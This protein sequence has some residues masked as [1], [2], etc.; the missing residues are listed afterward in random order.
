MIVSL[1][2]LQEMRV[3]LIDDDADDDDGSHVSITP[4]IVRS[5]PPATLN[6][7]FLLLLV[8]S[9][10]MFFTHVHYLIQ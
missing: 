3:A 2:T 5:L 6:T 1:V 4:F 10:D 7:N 8:L 9:L